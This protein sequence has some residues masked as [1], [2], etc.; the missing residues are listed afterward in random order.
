MCMILH[1]F[2][3]K[4]LVSL[5]AIGANYT[6][7]AVP[8]DLADRLA[9]VV[10]FHTSRRLAKSFAP[11]FA[12]FCCRFLL[13]TWRSLTIETRKPE[14][15]HQNILTYMII[16][17]SL[18]IWSGVEG[19]G[20]LTRNTGINLGYTKADQRHLLIR[21]HREQV[22]PRSFGFSV[23]WV[24]FQTSKSAASHLR[25]HNSFCFK[26]VL[27]ISVSIRLYGYT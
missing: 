19:Q 8:I 15:K 24:Q 18:K 9:S 3:F 11:I 13:K 27:N 26:Q 14:Q 23:T 21:W 25:L 4:A 22:H 5:R 6:W 7:H 1:L 20:K 12:L 16:H 17:V 2:S 10:A